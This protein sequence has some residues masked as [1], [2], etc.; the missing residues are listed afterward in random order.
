[1]ERN[2]IQLLASQMETRSDLVELLNKVKCDMLGGKAHPFQLRQI[3]YYCN[4]KRSDIRRY[5]EFT[6]LKKS[7]GLREISAPVRGLKSILFS[8]NAILQAI[9][10]PSKFAMGFAQGRSVVDNAKVHVGQRYIYNIDLKDFFPSI[11]KSRVWARLKCEP[12]NFSDEIANTIAGL[13]SI[14]VKSDSVERFVLPQ[15][16]P[17]SPLLTNAICDTLDR[18]LGA[19]AKRFGMR[20]SRYADDITFSSMHFVYGNDGN[21][22]KE[23]KRIITSQNFTINEKKTRL[24]ILGKSRQEVTGLTIS[25]KV[26]VAR[27]YFR[28]IKTL[29]NIWDHY[30]YIAACESYIK[31]HCGAERGQCVGMPKLEAVLAGKLQYMKMVK[32]SDDPAYQKLQTRFNV[33]KSRIEGKDASVDK[34]VAYLHT[35]GRASFLRLV[36]NGEVVIDSASKVFYKQNEQQCPVVVSRGITSEELTSLFEEKSNDATIWDKYRISLCESGRTQFYMLHKNFKDR[37]YKPCNNS[38][39]LEDIGNI[40]TNSKLIKQ[41]NQPRKCNEETSNILKRIGRCVK[42]F[43]IG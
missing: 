15:G 5:V 19:L 26:N 7:G 9:Y 16:A 41:D 40:F 39:K 31:T 8:L 11:D 30:G 29:L 42:K 20:Y 10:T 6:I 23:L 2:E 32:G 24:Q 3:T 17:T 33:L 35:I 14:R 22:I 13:C 34:D 18:R 36:K 4:P 21:F 12:F 38:V 37:K 28:E 25:D 1:M 43:L 27:K